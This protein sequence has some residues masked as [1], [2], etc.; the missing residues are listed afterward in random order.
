MCM[1]VLSLLH[2]SYPQKP[3]VCIESPGIEVIEGCE[4]HGCWKPDPLEE[5]PVL[6]T[7]ERSLSRYLL[8]L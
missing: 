2:A 8:Y 7:T 5:Q 3:E 6:L 1:S 4:P